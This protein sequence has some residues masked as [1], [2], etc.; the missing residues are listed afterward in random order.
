MNDYIALKEGKSR[1]PVKLT[2]LP[3]NCGK[4]T[5]EV[6]SDPPKGINIGKRVKYPMIDGTL[7]ETMIELT[8]VTK[9]VC[10]TNPAVQTS[11]G[12]VKFVVPGSV[13]WFLKTWSS[14]KF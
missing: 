1:T 7:N 12:D 14:F 6:D 10:T 11:R 3:W 9:L 4:W 13:F 2:A 8:V 5:I